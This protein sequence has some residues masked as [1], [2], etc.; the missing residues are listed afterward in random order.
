MIVSSLELYK[1]AKSEGY[2][3]GAFN[4]STIEVTKAIISAAEEMNAP[5]VIETSSKE[6]SFLDAKVL[7]DVITDLA[8]DL[9]IPVAIH[10]DHGQNLSEVEEA[11]AAGYTSV[12]IDAS[13]SPYEKNLAVTKAV[14]EYAHSKGIPVEGELGH[15][16]GASEKHDESFKIDQSTLTDPVKA[17]EFVKATEIDVLASA[18]G[19][20][21]GIYEDEP[22]L[23]FNRLAEI[24]KLNI[25]LSL[26]G[27]SGIPAE[28]I[29]K[30]IELG[31]CKINVNTELRMAFTGSLR[32][33][34]AEN[35][36]EVVPYKYLP[37]EIAAVKEVVEQKIRLFGSINKA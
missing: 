31:I 19:N 15:V 25:P 13:A 3:V 14:V 12:H 9:S 28:Q 17:A 20:V 16:G 29:K 6:M 22:E 34:L 26:H 33:E 24:S 8:K 1:K 7:V 10:L 23:D 2:A 21:H 18:I 36:E 11:I 37:E 32:K 4:T 35:P 5:V 27:G 30:A